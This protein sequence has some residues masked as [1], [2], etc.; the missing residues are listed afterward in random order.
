MGNKEKNS[1]SKEKAIRV[2]SIQDPLRK[3]ILKPCEARAGHGAILLIV[4]LSI[5]GGLTAL[6][7]KGM[8][9]VYRWIT[10]P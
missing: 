5:I 2:N 6:I 4:A 7:I 3:R 1:T 9:W 10:S 8:Q